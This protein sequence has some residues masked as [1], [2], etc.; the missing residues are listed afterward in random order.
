MA[1]EPARAGAIH[2]YD[3]VIVRKF[4]VYR[5]VNYPWNVNGIE[6]CFQ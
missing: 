6:K 5:F 3:M 2:N 1:A 4:V